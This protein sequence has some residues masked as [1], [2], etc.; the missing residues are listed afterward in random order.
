MPPFKAT[1]T[2]GRG[3]GSEEGPLAKIVSIE[4]THRGAS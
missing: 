2:V 1:D 4:I 3:S